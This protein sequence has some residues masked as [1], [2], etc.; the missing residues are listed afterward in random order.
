MVIICLLGS[1]FIS[2]LVHNSVP[3][4]VTNSVPDSVTNFYWKLFYA[5]HFL[6]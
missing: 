6:S 3:T 4:K 1:D 2:V 5:N